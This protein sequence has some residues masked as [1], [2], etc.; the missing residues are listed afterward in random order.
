MGREGE[1]VGKEIELLFC[2]H[3]QKGDTA[4]RIRVKTKSYPSWLYLL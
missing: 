3:V 4:E 1:V 2:L